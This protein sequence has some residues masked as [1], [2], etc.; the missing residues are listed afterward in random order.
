[1]WAMEKSNWPEPDSRSPNWRIPDQKRIRPS[2]VHSLDFGFQVGLS[3]RPNDYL[4][5]HRL[6][7][8]ANCWDRICHWKSAHQLL[9]SP[10]P[11][12][13]NKIGRSRANHPL[14]CSQWEEKH[15]SH[16]YERCRSSHS[17]NG[18]CER[19][20]KCK[21]WFPSV[22]IGLCGYPRRSPLLIQNLSR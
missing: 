17:S 3:G 14:G 18:L 11:H 9:R 13:Q 21:P 15:L 2:K 19:M 6:S 4:K 8:L 1:M 20:L 12:C 5:R 16:K 7:R 22:P 10:A